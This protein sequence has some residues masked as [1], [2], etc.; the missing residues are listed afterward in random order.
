MD[1]KGNWVNSMSVYSL[2]TLIDSRRYKT[3]AFLS[4]SLVMLL[5]QEIVV[6]T[7]HPCSAA[8]ERQERQKHKP[9]VFLA[10]TKSIHICLST[11]IKPTDP[12]H[13][14]II[15]ALELDNATI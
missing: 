7:K 5:M 8:P 10:D 15:K 1:S 11:H 12:K 9:G 6:G 2:L 3:V 13:G 14:Q 4:L